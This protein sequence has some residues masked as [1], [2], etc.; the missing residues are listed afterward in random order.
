[1]S[2]QT[3]VVA[4]YERAADGFAA[5]LARVDGRWD[6]GSP[7]EDW[8]AADVVEHVLNGAAALIRNLGGEL[9]EPERADE[10]G[11]FDA[12]R[13]AAAEAARQPGALDRM[14]QGPLGGDMPAAVFLGIIAT[15]TLIHTWDL[16]RA[17]GEDVELDGD[18]LHRSWQNIVPMDEM[19]RR[20]GVFGP[21]VPVGADATPQ[22]Q[23]LAF[24]GRD[25]R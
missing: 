14:V 17:L 10:T 16:A 23:A 22:Q 3:D 13:A 18:L 7:C 6:A 4:D 21:K 25:A 1:M 12:L 19:I 15:D 20:P 2:R 24:F 5:V 11:R 8:T 9:S